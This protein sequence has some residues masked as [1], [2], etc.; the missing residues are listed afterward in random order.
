MPSFGH[1]ESGALT[2]RV[3][4]VRVRLSRRPG[5]RLNAGRST[6]HRCR[7]LWRQDA[8]IPKD[9]GGARM[10]AASGETDALWQNQR[11]VVVYVEADTKPTLR[12]RAS[13]AQCLGRIDL[14]SLNAESKAVSRLNNGEKSSFENSPYRSKGSRAACCTRSATDR[15]CSDCSLSTF[16]KDVG[17]SCFLEHAYGFPSVLPP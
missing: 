3:R 12:Q 1:P 16:A 15:I 14:I 4:A 11:D 7:R 6:G 2:F 9:A 5:S 17:I 13:A 8:F 10:V